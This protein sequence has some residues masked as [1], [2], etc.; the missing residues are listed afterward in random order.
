MSSLADGTLPSAE[1][2][3]RASTSRAVSDACSEQGAAAVGS[4]FAG[5]LYGVN[6]LFERIAD[7]PNNITRFLV[8]SRESARPTGDDKTSV[9]FT[10]SVKPGALV[11]VL[12]E[13]RDAGV[14]LSHIDKRPSG[15]EN[16]EYSFFVD[17]VG[18]EEEE[19][20]IRATEAARRHCISFRIL[21]SYPRATR[22]L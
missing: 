12:G 20:M 22:I 16:W 17:A 1:L 6:L 2:V 18:H 19:P 10:T 15:R 5:E 13:F 9:M 8:L 3:P 4:P 7:K 21:G 11:D 14:N